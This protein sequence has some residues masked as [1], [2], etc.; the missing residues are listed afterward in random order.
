MPVFVESYP[1]V[2]RTFQGPLPL[3]FVFVVHIVSIHVDIA[4]YLLVIHVVPT[5][6]GVSL[7]KSSF[8]DVRS[9]PC[10]LQFG[11]LDGHSTPRHTKTTLSLLLFWA[12]SLLAIAFDTVICFFSFVASRSQ[13]LNAKLDS[14]YFCC[15]TCLVVVSSLHSSSLV[16]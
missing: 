5:Q 8:G 12:V 11:L 1:I 13:R 15:V 6:P 9:F 3:Y 7:P 14:S 10:L 16:L 2:F 4:C